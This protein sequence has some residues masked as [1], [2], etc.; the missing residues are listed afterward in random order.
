[1]TIQEIMKGLQQDGHGTKAMGG[2]VADDILPYVKSA[3]A[4]D[5]LGHGKIVVID[6]VHC[7]FPYVSPSILLKLQQIRNA[8][9]KGDED[10]IDDR[11][12][13]DIKNIISS[14]FALLNKANTISESSVLHFDLSIEATVCKEMIHISLSPCL[15]NTE[16]SV[17]LGVCMLTYSARKR[18]GN[19]LV[20][21][22]QADE[23]YE[24]RH[25]GW[26]QAKNSHLTNMEKVVIVNSINGKSIKDIAKILSV[27]I[28]TVKAHRT[29]IFKKLRVKNI[30]EAVQYAEDYNLI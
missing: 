10:L 14:Y 23:H 22:P 16:K 29:N 30:T 6:F 15:C 13:F 21:L 12:L 4:L 18:P 11:Q 26:V 8:R 17:I 20:K 3:H 19:A 27:S 28:V 24:Y 5:R 2:Q 1:M 25:D 9:T 7:S